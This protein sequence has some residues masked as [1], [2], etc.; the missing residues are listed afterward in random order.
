[1]GE[2]KPGLEFMDKGFVSTSIN[3]ATAT[4]FGAS[5]VLGGG[6]TGVVVEITVPTGSSVVSVNEVTHSIEMAEQEEILLQ[7]GSTFRVTSI[8]NSVPPR[9]RVELKPTGKALLSP[10][11]RWLNGGPQPEPGAE[12]AFQ[13]SLASW[14]KAAIIAEM[15]R[16]AQ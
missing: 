10:R 3:E 5:E 6:G 13:A 2:L 7:R 12:E 11:D 4:E 8:S 15:K 1:M 9:I 16:L 14:A